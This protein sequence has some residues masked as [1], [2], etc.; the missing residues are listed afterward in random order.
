MLLL[1]SCTS[2]KFTNTLPSQPKSEYY[3]FHKE[4]GSF[5]SLIDTSV[6]YVFGNDMV[7]STHEYKKIEEVKLYQF[8]AL[9]SNGIAFYSCRRTRSS[10]VRSYRNIIILNC[11]TL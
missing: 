4:H 9:K 1:G 10:A 8:I 5:N 3:T 6:I 2:V 7:L 11:Q